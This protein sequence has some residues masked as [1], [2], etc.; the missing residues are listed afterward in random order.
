MKKLVYGMMALA[1]LASCNSDDDMTVNVPRSNMA[2]NFSLN[3][4]ETKAI[5]ESTTFPVGQTIGIYGFDAKTSTINT[6]GWGNASGYT[7][8]LAN[9]VYTTQELNGS[10]VQNLKP[11]DGKIAYFQKGDDAAV[12]LYGYYPYT[13][14]AS[15]V[16]GDVAPTIPVEAKADYNTTDDY[17]YTGRI[18]Q[19]VTYATIPLMFK[20]A[21]GGLKLKLRCADETVG[22]VTVLKAT[23]VT[24]RGQKG[25][26]N[27]ADGTITY[28]EDLSGAVTTFASNDLNVPVAATSA[29]EDLGVKFLLFP[30]SDV[31]EKVV[32]T[33]NRGS[34]PTNDPRTY[35]IT[36]ATDGD[37]TVNLVAGKFTILTLVFSPKD[38][39]F[40]AEIAEWTD[41]AEEN[42]EFSETDKFT[43]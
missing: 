20:H 35:E 17:M 32:I 31:I 23:V 4:A 36:A 24:R 25:T 7:E 12:V 13:A 9:G 18:Q 5:V 22:D 26:M 11:E 38:M 40:T 42:P 27:V 8:Y 21:M 19:P 1:A 30:G 14:E 28:D 6:V 15:S 29:G 33:L 10:G 2:L 37:H 16:Y 39:N 43:E 34:F 41:N 3:A